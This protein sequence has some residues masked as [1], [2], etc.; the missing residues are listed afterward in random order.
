MEHSV[1]HRAVPET[2]SVAFSD[3]RETMRSGSSSKCE[4][5]NEG[6]SE[7]PR[8]SLRVTPR[9]RRPWTRWRPSAG[10]V[11]GWVSADQGSAAVRRCG[12]PGR[13]HNPGAGDRCNRIGTD[14]GELAR[15]RGHPHQRRGHGREGPCCFPRPPGC[16]G[17]PRGRCRARGS[18]RRSVQPM[19]C[20]VAG[21]AAATR[22]DPNRTGVKRVSRGGPPRTRFGRTGHGR[23]RPAV[24]KTAARPR[25]RS[26]SDDRAFLESAAG[27]DSQREITW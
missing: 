14:L 18:T 19:R 21:A 10:I 6:D 3:G 17:R 2:V 25:R 16:C 20:Q 9:S 5:R 8:Q 27:S 13:H 22:E 4:A 15:S 7:E 26:R 12:A 11:T 1:A 24:G 23:R